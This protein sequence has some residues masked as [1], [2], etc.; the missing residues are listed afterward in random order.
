[1]NRRRYKNVPFSKLKG[2][3]LL[4][5]DM[6]YQRGSKQTNWKDYLTVVYRDLV[7]N[8]KEKMVIEEPTINLFV[9]KPEYRNFRKARHFLSQDMVDVKEIKYKDVLREIAKVGGPETE[10]FYRTHTFKERKELYKYPY[11]LGGD[12][13]IETYYRTIWKEQVGYPEKAIPS[14]IF[15]DIEVDQIDYE[16]NIARHGECPV[17]AVTVL[18]D[19]VNVCHTFLYDDGKNPQI[20]DFIEHQEEF[21]ERLHKEF[22][23]RNGKFEYRIYMFQNEA[24]MII[25]LFKLINTICRDFSLIWNMGFDIPYLIDRL[26]ELKID[27]AQVMCSL[28][29]PTNTLYYYE[30]KNTFDWANKRDYFSISAYTHYSDQC[31]NYASLRKSQGTVKKVNLDAVAAKE[32][33]PGK[34]TY[35][36]VATIR[37][38]PYVDYILFVLYNIGDVLTQ[39]MIERKVKD[40]DNLYLISSTNNIGYTDAL[41]QTV[42]FRGLM[43]GYLK[44]RGI[45]L[46]HNTNFG[47]NTSGKYDENGDRIGDVDDDEDETFEGAINGNPLY[48]IANGL[49]MYGTPSKFLYGIVI[50]FDFS[51]GHTRTA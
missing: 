9:V 37:T 16:G 13:P 21:Q 33:V 26:Y 50:D 27:A 47:N 48:N 20:K 25:Q 17:N 28:D 19:S 3:D 32:K 51:S 39:A 10:E 6:I 1:M 45:V 35:K 30:D 29:F 15:L 18:D 41:K 44:Q 4:L 7:K 43:Y 11:C 8:T 49:S 40:I 36:T 34:V 23:E 31:I 14:K 5:C 42:T 46:G 2:R 22:D 24:D 38:L 12:V